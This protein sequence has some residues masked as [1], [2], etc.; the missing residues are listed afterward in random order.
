[1][2]RS[3][4]DRTVGRIILEKKDKLAFITLNRPEKLNS[5][6]GQMITEL[7]NIA[8][9]VEKDDTINVVILT[10]AGD[11]AFSSGSDLAELKGIMPLELKQRI[12]APNIIRKITKPTIAMIQGYALGGGLELALACD[13]RMASE[14]AQLGFPEIG[15]GWLPGGGGGTQILP[16]LV[17]EGRAMK[18]ILTGRSVTAA[19]AK[20]I[21]LIEEVVPVGQLKSE[22][23]KLAKEIAEKPLQVLRLAKEA[24]GASIRA[25][26]EV[27]LNYERA[28]NALCFMLKQTESKKSEG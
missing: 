7:V 3:R 24:V 13:I 25:N 12:E 20:E 16:R 15:L 14:N 6:N 10:G 4:E 26:L 18:M 9:D 23:E 2:I 1:M 27:R 21:G 28:L 19:E 8:E 22:T 11:R 5:L 17:G